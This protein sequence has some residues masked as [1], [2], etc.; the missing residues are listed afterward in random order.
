MLT[1]SSRSVVVLKYM[2]NN[3]HRSG[4]RELHKYC[5]RNLPRSYTGYCRPSPCLLSRLIF[6][7]SKCLTKDA[8]NDTGSDC[9]ATLSHVEA[10]ALLKNVGL[11]KLANHLDVV[12]GH[13][14]LGRSILSALGPCERARLIGSSDE[15]LGPVVVTEAS[16]ATTLLL[17]E[18]IHGD[19]ELLVGLDLS[20]DGDDHTTA[21]ILTLDTTEE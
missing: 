18:D 15:H 1:P 5:T 8:S 9:A 6:L 11:V 14:K 16:V 21:D 3:K 10:L 12:T 19:K 2:M 13:D 7:T 20:R 4:E 17:A